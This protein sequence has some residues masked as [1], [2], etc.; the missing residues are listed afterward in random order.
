M[1]SAR[2]FLACVCQKTKREKMSSFSLFF[3]ILAARVAAFVKRRH[4]PGSKWGLVRQRNKR[5]TCHK[6]PCELMCGPTAEGD[7]EEG[8]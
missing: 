6:L 2:S 7:C 1:V 4:C 3:R 5:A 8:L